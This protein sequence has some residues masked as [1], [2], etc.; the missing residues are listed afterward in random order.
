MSRLGTPFVHDLMEGAKGV[1]LGGAGA[2]SRRREGRWL[3][4]PE[5]EVVDAGA[6][7]CR[8]NG[9]LTRVRIERACPYTSAL[10]AAR[11]A[12]RIS[13][14]RTS[15]A[16]ATDEIDWEATLAFRRY[17]WSYGLG[18]AEAMDTSQR[19]MGFRGKTRGS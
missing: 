1:Q 5:L 8:S 9:V 19:G 3:D 12:D 14:R 17:L 13:R 18:V 11:V 15:V 2:R 6:D 10:E 7:T 16:A 4:V